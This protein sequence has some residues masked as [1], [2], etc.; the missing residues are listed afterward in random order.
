MVID[1]LEKYTPVG[2]FDIG[3]EQINHEYE[4][5]SRQKVTDFLQEHD[6]DINHAKNLH[7]NDRSKYLI[8][9]LLSES[10]LQSPTAD[11][12]PKPDSDTG[13]IF[14]KPEIAPLGHLAIRFLEEQGIEAKTGETI[15]PSHAE[16]TATYGYMLKK[17]PD[18]INV[19]I[20]Q[21]S[22]GLQPVT[23][24]HLDA[25]EY[26]TLLVRRGT[27]PTVDDDLDSM[28]DKLFCGKI[29]DHQLCL[30]RSVS[31]P[32]MRQAGFDDLTSFAS[33]FDPVNYFR[34]THM[35]KVYVAYNGIH[36]P[37]NEAEKTRNI[38]DLLQKDNNE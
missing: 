29:S 34:D 27:P 9:A 24:R 33:V 10:V 26:T 14:I 23:F 35:T 19:Y 22:L 32:I 4:I 8:D 7:P 6:V 17:Y 5:V 37:S 20:V 13:I 31:Y 15:Y 1:M 11:Y 21:R 12:G 16:W 25:S 28:F 2:Q 3:Q 18:V 36:A 30:R 38:Q